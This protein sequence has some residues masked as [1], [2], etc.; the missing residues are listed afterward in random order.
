MLRPGGHLDQAVKGSVNALFDLLVEED[1]SHEGDQDK[2]VS[3]YDKTEIIYLGPDENMTNELTTWIPDQA[4]RRPYRYA[5]AFMSSK[6]GEG[7]NHKEYGVTSEG[8]K[9]LRGQYPTVF[10]SRSS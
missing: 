4:K 2:L 7:I 10:R 6:P 8:A 3:Y 9:C 1:E 5:P